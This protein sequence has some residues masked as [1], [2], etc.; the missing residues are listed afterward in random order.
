MSL[1]RL[2]WNDYRLSSINAAAVTAL[3]RTSVATVTLINNTN[4]LEAGEGMLCV[5]TGALAVAVPAGVP[6]PNGWPPVMGAGA[7]VLGVGL[8]SMCTGS[9]GISAAVPEDLL[10]GIEIAG[11]IGCAGAGG[12]GCTSFTGGSVATVCE[13]F[14]SSGMCYPLCFLQLYRVSLSS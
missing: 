8:K 4:F 6:A 3:P 9:T 1:K 13:G 11:D 10:G 14:C 5:V 2:V 12:S 7:E